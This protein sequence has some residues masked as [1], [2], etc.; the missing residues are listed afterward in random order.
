MLALPE[1]TKKSLNLKLRHDIFIVFPE[2]GYD[3][4]NKQ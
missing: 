1:E 4:E 3:A 2:V